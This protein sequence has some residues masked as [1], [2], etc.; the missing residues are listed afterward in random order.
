[1][2]GPRCQGSN[3]E[4]L[5][6]G[7][8][9]RRGCCAA[10]CRECRAVGCGECDP[11]RAGAEVTPR[12]WRVGAVRVEKPSVCTAES[13]PAPGRVHPGGGPVTAFGGGGHDENVCRMCTRAWGSRVS[14]VYRGG[15]LGGRRLRASTRG[16]SRTSFARCCLSAFVRVLTSCASS[17]PSAAEIRKAWVC[18]TAGCDLPVEPRC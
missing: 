13:R 18:G 16:R 12:G 11:V 14:A 3:C 15:V 5:V 6:P 7:G 8:G 9:L 1:M 4:G 10:G 2:S 17:L